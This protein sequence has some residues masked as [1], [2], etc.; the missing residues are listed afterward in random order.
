MI[1]VVEDDESIRELVK[2]ALMSFSYSVK[3]FDSAEAALKAISLSV[4]DLAIFDITLPGMSG[5]Q[6]TKLLRQSSGTK[7][8]PI[9][10]LTAKGSEMDK[11]SGLDSGA[12]DYI[13][14]PFS[15]MELAA[16]IRAAFRRLPGGGGHAPEQKAYEFSDLSVN[17][18]TREVAINGKGINLTFK[19]YEL[20]KMLM[21]EKDRI[22][23]R[24]E[25]LGA[26]WGEGYMGEPRTLDMHIRTLRAKLGDD[27][28]NPKY[29]KTVRNVGYRFVGKQL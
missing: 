24:E 9:I 11:V 28:D 7:M 5:T 3:E 19:E 12:D 8:L 13:V 15:V 27:A 25:L 1:Y 10:L 4:P 20:L 21:R 17:H 14:K 18:D 6:A 29:I 23:L 2:L 26:V 16:R 22:V